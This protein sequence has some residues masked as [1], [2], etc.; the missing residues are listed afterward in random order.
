M[1]TAALALL[2]AGSL[3]AGFTV[4]VT[5]SGKTYHRADATCIAV[6]RAEVAKVD[7]ETA[8]KHGLRMCAACYK[9]RKV[10]GAANDWAFPERAK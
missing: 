9:P 8:R 10:K 5:R 3:S 2:L 6:R 4:L 7:E 1:K